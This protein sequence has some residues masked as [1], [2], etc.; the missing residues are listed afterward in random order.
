MTIGTIDPAGSLPLYTEAIACTERSGDHFVNSIL[1]D[2]ACVTALEAGDLPAARAHLEAAAQ[3]AQQIGRES[4]TLRADLGYVL[5]AEGDLDGAWSAFQACLRIGRRNG[6]NW[7]MAMAIRGLACAD[8]CHQQR[9]RTVAGC[10]ATGPG[11]GPVRGPGRRII[12]APRV[13]PVPLPVLSVQVA[14]A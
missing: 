7:H 4:A 12:P 6:D 3:A 10:G 2:N 13:P 11:R 14:R 5:L 9:L 8:P 1:H